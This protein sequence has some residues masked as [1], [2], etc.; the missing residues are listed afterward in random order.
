[1][2]YFMPT[3]AEVLLWLFVINLGIVLG[4]GL[5]ELRVVVPLWA[6][7]PPASIGQP[8]SG[9]RFWA[10]AATGPLTLLCL[11]NLYLAWQ[12]LGP[13]H[14]WWLIAAVIVLIERLMTFGYFIPTILRLQRSERPPAEVR[15]S[16]SQWIAFNFARIA[17]VL[18]AFLLALKALALPA[19]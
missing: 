9:L 13:R 6:S 5:Y 7:N 8:D 11:A 17:L 15:A 2:V 4:A 14:N 19:P 16:F 10:W 1:M 18:A 12:S 3:V